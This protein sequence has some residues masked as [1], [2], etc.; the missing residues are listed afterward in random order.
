MRLLS[1]LL[2]TLA[3]TATHARADLIL[4]EV[5]YD[6]SGA[7]EGYE[8]VELANTGPGPVDLAGYQ[9]GNGGTDYSYSVVP[10][11]GVVE[12]CETFVVG[13][14]S[15]PEN[16]SPVFDQVFDFSPDFQNSGS[17]PDGVALFAPGANPAVDCPIDA[18]IYGSSPNNNLVDETCTL[19][20]PDVADVSA[21]SSVERSSASGDWIAQPSPDPN[22]LGFELVCEPVGTESSSWSTL[23]SR[24]PDLR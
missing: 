21:G 24:Y 15:V 18:V 20:A 19:A 3:F 7:D 16:G 8:W 14:T 17:S 23:K 13:F 10:L 5:Y 2:I 11:E 1:L 22:Q 9:L 12:A 6:H 4:T